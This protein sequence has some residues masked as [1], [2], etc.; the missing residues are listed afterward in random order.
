MIKAVIFDMDGLMFD[1]EHLL[2][3]A[4]DYAGEK[5]GIGKAGIMAIETLGI[6]NADS[7]YMWY[8][9]YGDAYDE[10]K[11]KEYTYEFIEKYFTEKGIP[12]KKGLDELLAYLAEKGY[13]TAV[14]TSS[15]KRSLMRNLT[16]AGLEN[17][18]DV[19]VNCN[20]VSMSKPFPDVYLKAMELLGL[21]ADECLVLEDSINGIKAASAAGCRAIMIPD[22]VQ[23]TEEI[24]KLLF[25]KCGSLDEVIAVLEQL[26]K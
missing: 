20:M 19:L 8:D 5:L 12:K 23:P 3:E 14:A 2:Y 6:S 7:R 11:I 10:G 13:R 26:N 24:E 9:R 17:R 25:K 1:T 15:S 21:T 22:L 16:A 4:W 18:F